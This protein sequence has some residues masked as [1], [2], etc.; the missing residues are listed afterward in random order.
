M[1][2]SAFLGTLLGYFTLK[3]SKK[4]REPVLLFDS[5][6]HGF[7]LPGSVHLQPPL[8]TM[9]TPMKE[10]QLAGHG[11]EG[12]RALSQPLQTTLTQ[13]LLTAKRV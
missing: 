7:L 9:I 2:F 6:L 13:P 3:L 5:L 4:L 1:S 11:A 8:Y 12:S 10:A